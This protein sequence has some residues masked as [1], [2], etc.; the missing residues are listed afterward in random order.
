M[1]KM[2][3]I[4]IPDEVDPKYVY[5][6]DTAEKKEYWEKRQ[7]ESEAAQKEIESWN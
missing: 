2:K 3:N 1:D 7:K 6:P 4:T 5:G